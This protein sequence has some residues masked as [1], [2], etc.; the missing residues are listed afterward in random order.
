MKQYKV[1]IY[2]IAVAAIALLVISDVVA[3]R[4]GGGWS[5]GGRGGG[6]Y[7]RGGGSAPGGGGRGQQRDF[8]HSD[9]VHPDH[10]PDHRPD[11]RPD[12]PD[13]NGTI[14]KN[15]NV[16]A[17]N[18]GWYGYGAAD[19]ALAGMMMVTAM[20]AVA[21]KSSE[22]NTVIIEQ[23]AQPAVQ[24]APVIP[25]IGAQVPM[26]P[27]GCQAKNIGGTLYYQSGSAWYRPYFGASGVY[28]QVVEPPA[29]T[30]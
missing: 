9:R 14:T 22:S 28:Y 17:P 16:N 7:S 10:N 20:G 23:P 2:M 21:A 5:G 12:W 18:G 25:S 15:V 8:Q 1:C 13:H 30:S 27:Q 29:A 26:L 4:G 19:D 11:H 24:A 3:A 6:G